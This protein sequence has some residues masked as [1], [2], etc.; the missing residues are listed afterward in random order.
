MC[1]VH[2]P[3]AGGVIVN[4]LSKGHEPYLSLGQISASYCFHISS[5]CTQLMLFYEATSGKMDKKKIIGNKQL[6]RNGS[7]SVVQ[8]NFQFSGSGQI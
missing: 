7:Q 4:L 3:P 5:F 2:Y 6:S 8:T 1:H